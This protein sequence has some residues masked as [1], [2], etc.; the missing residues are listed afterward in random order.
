MS[1]RVMLNGGLTPLRNTRA[2]VSEPTTLNLASAG[3]GNGR[4]ASNFLNTLPP[5]VSY[6]QI[7][8]VAMP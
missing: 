8:I 7:Q 3:V 1:N 6:F 2:T 4:H 5:K